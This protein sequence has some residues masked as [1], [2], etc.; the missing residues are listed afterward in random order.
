MF[1]SNDDRRRSR[2]AGAWTIGIVLGLA[3]G[4]AITAASVTAQSSAPNDV[5][6]T[7]SF[8]TE[9]TKP[10]PERGKKV[11]V[12]PL[13]ARFLT[14]DTA[15]LGPVLAQAPRERTPAREPSPARLPTRAEW[16]V[17]PVRPP[18]V[19]DHGARPREAPPRDQDLQ[20]P[21]HHRPRRDDSRGPVAARLP[22]L[23]PVCERLVVRRPVPRRPRP[24][25]V[26]E[27]LGSTR[28][29]SARREPGHGCREP[30]ARP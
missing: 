13:R 19:G 29:Q 15:R 24:R 3:V 6:D 25:C 18:G 17:P 11:A 20:R 22:G 4:V 16:D 14:L 2:R 1:G 8:W 23:G 12:T 9:A 28:V 27:L 30:R 26:C 5:N 7:N 10:E 21:G